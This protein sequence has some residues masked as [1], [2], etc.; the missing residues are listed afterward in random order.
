M[1]N[2]IVD[3]NNINIEPYCRYR[4]WRVTC[5]SKRLL[6]SLLR[7]FFECLR[8]T[9]FFRHSTENI[10][11]SK[12]KNL[13]IDSDYRGPKNLDFETGTKSKIVFFSSRFNVDVQFN[14]ANYST[15]QYIFPGTRPIHDTAAGRRSRKPVLLLWEPRLNT[16]AVL[17]CRLF[18]YDIFA[19]CLLRVSCPAGGPACHLSSL[20]NIEREHNKN[21]IECENVNTQRGFRN[22]AVHH[23]NQIISHLLLTIFR[24]VRDDESPFKLQTHSSTRIHLVYRIS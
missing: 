9:S 16:S 15:E 20:G 19:W 17:S 12:S 21:N 7:I 11:T 1:N 6:V 2:S 14:T 8:N 3:S 23:H 10:E 13:D 4:Y 18:I 24:G 22:R 5:A